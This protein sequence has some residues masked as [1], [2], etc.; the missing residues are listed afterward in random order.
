MK[1]DIKELSDIMVQIRDLVSGTNAELLDAAIQI[2]RNRI[3]RTG[4]II[5]WHS[6][7]QSAPEERSAIDGLAIANEEGFLEISRKLEEIA[8]K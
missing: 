3:L 6:S 1:K 4:L 2:Q 7:P 8:I 5:E